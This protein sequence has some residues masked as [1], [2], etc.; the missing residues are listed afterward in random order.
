MSA[1][2]HHTATILILQ[3][4]ID[5]L[6]GAALIVEKHFNRLMPQLLAAFV[7]VGQFLFQSLI[8]AQIDVNQWTMIQI[9]TDLIN[10]GTS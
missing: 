6:D 7:F 4:G 3:S 5:A 9:T 10:F 2:T 1:N 8:T